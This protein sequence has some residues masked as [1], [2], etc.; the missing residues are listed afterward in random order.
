VDVLAVGA[1]PDD[2]E[3]GIGGL[4]HKVTQLGYRVGILDL[5]RGE[6]S[7]RGTITE[8]AVEAANAARILGVAQR[9]NAGL[10]DG[11]IE[12]TPEYRL[13][14]IRFVRASRPRIFIAPMSHDRHPDHHTAHDLV[15][16]A[17]YFSGLTQIE[18]GQGPYRPPRIYYYHPYCED[19]PPPLIVDISDHFEV[20]LEA[21]RA[22]ASQ[23]HNLNYEG[24]PTY[25]SSASFWETIRTR[26]AYWGSRINAAYGEPLYTDGPIGADLPPGL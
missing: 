22:H 25:I 13:R 10:P 16:D 9:D 24:Q 4:I 5:T 20:K 2:V 15:R 19:E 17:A 3:L 26:A 14:V 23:F 21:L 6:M 11:A 12:N 1:H 18:T 8:R 7:S